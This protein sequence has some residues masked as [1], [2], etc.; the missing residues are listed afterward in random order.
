[1]AGLWPE[2]GVACHT[3]TQCNSFGNI[4]RTCYHRHVAVGCCVVSEL[5]A[6]VF[7]P[8]V[9]TPAG[10]DCTGVLARLAGAHCDG[11][12]WARAIFHNCRRRGIDRRPCSESQLTNCI[13]ARAFGASTRLNHT[14]VCVARRNGSN[15]SVGASLASRRC[16][17]L[18][19]LSIHVDLFISVSC[20]LCV[21]ASQQ[22]RFKCACDRVG[23]A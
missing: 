11:G 16:Y 15:R 9:G 23:S 10:S 14:G 18:R 5:T 8:A 7:T 3:R 4:G 6:G 12:N 1:M 2:S 20:T 13:V 22:Q 17:V 21:T 19:L